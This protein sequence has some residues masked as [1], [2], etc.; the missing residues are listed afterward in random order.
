M[1][2]STGIFEKMNQLLQEHFSIV[3]VDDDIITGFG[4]IDKT[5]YLD[6]Q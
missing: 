2:D 4:D 1:Y 3:A 5:G 6:R